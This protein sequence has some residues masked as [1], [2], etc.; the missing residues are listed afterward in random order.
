MEDNK[1]IDLF[2]LKPKSTFEQNIIGDILKLKTKCDCWLNVGS[3]Y[4]ETA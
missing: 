1:Y 2:E 3:C 4:C